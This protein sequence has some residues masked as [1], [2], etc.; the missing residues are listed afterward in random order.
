MLSRLVDGC[1]VCGELS[2]WFGAFFARGRDAA[3]VERRCRDPSVGYHCFVKCSSTGDRSWVSS[4]G[5]YY[6]TNIVLL[7]VLY[8]GVVATALRRFVV[9]VASDRACKLSIVL[10]LESPLQLC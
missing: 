7:C 2:E 5:S 10:Q 8:D 1:C 4:L 9:L 6:L 3:K